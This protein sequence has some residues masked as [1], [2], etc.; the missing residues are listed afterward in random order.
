MFLR[1]K[2]FSNIRRV[3]REIQLGNKLV[4]VVLNKTISNLWFKDLLIFKRY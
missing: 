1:L 2:I 4:D 3:K